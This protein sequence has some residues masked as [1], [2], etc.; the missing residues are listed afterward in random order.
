MPSS[1]QRVEDIFRESFHDSEPFLFIHP[2]ENRD[3]TD[4]ELDLLRRRDFKTRWLIC[5]TAVCHKSVVLRTHFTDNHKFESHLNYVR[6]LFKATHVTENFTA[7]KTAATE[8]LNMFFT[9]NSSEY[10]SFAVTIASGLSNCG[11]NISFEKSDLMLLEESEEM[12]ARRKLALLM[13]LLFSK[14]TMYR[15]L[16]QDD[17]NNTYRLVHCSTKGSKDKRPLLYAI[18]SFL[19]QFCLTA[20]VV[21][22]NISTG[23]QSYQ[24][25]NMP[26]ALLTFIY[27]AIIAYPGMNDSEIAM[28]LYGKKGPLQMLDFFV[29]QI[30][31]GVLLFSG[32]FVILIQDSFIEAVLNTAAL[33][34][35]P[36]IDDQLPQLLGLDTDS[37]I[38]NYLMYQTLREFDKICQMDDNKITYE[39]LKSVNS[40]IGVPFCD[41]YLTNDPEQ[42]AHPIDG[43]N[44]TP[45]Q[46]HAGRDGAGHQIDPS[47]FVTEK[48]LIRKIVWSYTT[49]AK[50]LNTSHP[51]I[52]Y[53]KIV[54]LNGEII[55]ICQ[56]GV[57]DDIQVSD[58]TN[59]LEGVFIITSFHMS[60]AIFRLRVCGSPTARNFLDA[61]EYYSLWGLTSNASNA[62]ER[63]ASKSK[64]DFVTCEKQE[65][66]NRYMGM[67]TTTV[68][69]GIVEYF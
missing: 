11:E 18:F 64:G 52:G 25:R 57:N 1:F 65:D 13:D 29:N 40:S 9:L 32:F 2:D 5:S 28:K 63:E 45:Y 68:S 61:L 16:I 22:E 6:D 66:L 4:D 31:T 48:C 46:V 10:Y 8:L 58:F 69:S 23:I 55:E 39:Y 54:K 59:V 12:M 27:S 41:Y 44:Y 62:L 26:L 60:D 20:Y 53:L 49:S 51:R 37:I 36:D 67:D 50:Y 21:A 56:K 47:N 38:K 42:A 34:F 33:L 43:I 19:I 15:F 24:L 3:Y 14:V 17:G 30:L 7:A 35:I